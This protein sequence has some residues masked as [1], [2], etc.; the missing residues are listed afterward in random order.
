MQ[1]LKKSIRMKSSVALDE[2]SLK[3]LISLVNEYYPDNNARLIAGLRDNREVEFESVDKLLQHDNHGKAR[4]VALCIMCDKRYRLVFTCKFPIKNFICLSTV[5]VD[6]SMDD[7]NN[8]RL[9]N[10]KLNEFFAK[11]K[12][13]VIYTIMVNALVP[14]L[15]SVYTTGFLLLIEYLDFPFE[16]VST[17]F[18]IAIVV[19]AIS[20]ATAV[21][22]RPLWLRFFCPVQFLWGEEIKRQRHINKAIWYIMGIISGV[23]GNLIYNYFF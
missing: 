15:L 9:F 17:A 14:V 20:F 5:E 22:V 12:L 19:G 11:I 6:F 18:I 21:L 10:D 2:S 8:Y 4:I 1:T 13:P 23:A 3:A 7:D 16:I